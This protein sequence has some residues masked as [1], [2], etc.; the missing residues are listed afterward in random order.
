MRIFT[1]EPTAYETVELSDTP[2]DYDSLTKD[3]YI[4]KLAPVNITADGEYQIIKCVNSKQEKKDLWHEIRKRGFTINNVQNA[5]SLHYPFLLTTDYKGD[6]F[7]RNYLIR[8][9]GLKDANYSGKS[10]NIPFKG[11]TRWEKR[12]SVF[13]GTSVCVVPSRFE[14]FGMIVLEAMCHGVPVVYSENSGVAE[15][16]NAGLA[17]DFSKQGEVIE[18]MQRSPSPSATS[19]GI[20]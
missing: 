17:V 2:I 14:P 19:W 7:D 11:F 4:W 18:A 20:G 15:V 9:S 3:I 13:G 5:T 6:S 10:D 12:S 16:I 8:I 1:F